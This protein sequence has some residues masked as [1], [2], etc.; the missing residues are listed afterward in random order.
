MLWN[1]LSL[2]LLIGGTAL[3][4]VLVCSIPVLRAAVNSF[5]DQL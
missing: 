4:L 5:L 3:L 1:V 2:L